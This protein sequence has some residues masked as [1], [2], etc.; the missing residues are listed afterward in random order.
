MLELELDVGGDGGERGR[1]RGDRAAF[2]QLTSLDTA[3]DISQRAD[4]ISNSFD[5]IWGQNHAVGNMTHDPWMQQ[6]NLV[7]KYHLL[8]MLSITKKLSYTY[9]G[10]LGRF[11][12]L[13]PTANE[14][15]K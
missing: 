10:Q 9:I 11:H 12:I 2:C 4:V 7:P 15:R 14:P 3:C 1:G 8:N 13:M 5:H 6:G